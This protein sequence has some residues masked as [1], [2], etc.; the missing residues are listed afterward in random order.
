MFTKIKSI[1]YIPLWILEGIA[2]GLGGILP[3]VSGGT[4]CAAF[5]MYRLLVACI[6]RPIRGIGEHGR[7]LFWFLLGSVVGFVGLAGVGGEL[8]TRYPKET[9]TGF[10]GMLFGTIPAQ[11]K[12]AGKEGRSKK[13]ILALG[14]GFMGMSAILTCMKLM[15]AFEL[16]PTGGAFLLCG[17]LWGLG[18]LVPGLSA[19]SLILFFGLY[20]PMLEGI[21]KGDLGVLLPLAGGGICCVAFLGKAVAFGLARWYEVLSHGVLGAVLATAFGLLPSCG[22]SG[23]IW[24]GLGFGISYVLTAWG[25]EKE[26]KT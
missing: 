19:S 10:L 26:G 2:V 9:S 22:G 5:G 13:G 18:V 25:N 4:L 16:S 24:G 6:D 7:K 14:T 1:L 21:G 3:G 20:G 8:L 23:W 11:W 15:D 17:V 12:E